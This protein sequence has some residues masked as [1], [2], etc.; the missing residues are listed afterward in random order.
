MHILVTRPQ[1]EGSRMKAQLEAAGHQVT[2]D[3]LLRIFDLLRNKARLD[4]HAFFHAEPL[5]DSG[6]PVGRKD[7]HEVIFERNMET[8]RSRITLPA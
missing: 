7:P 3:P 4:R 8:G 1:P 5:H 2:L 6:N